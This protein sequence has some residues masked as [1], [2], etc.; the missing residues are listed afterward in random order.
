[1]STTQASTQET[2]EQ[3]EH[4][5]A[6]TTHHVSVTIITESDDETNAEFSREPYRITECIQC[7]AESRQR[8]N[9]R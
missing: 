4:C 1:M 6:K 3:C 7:G 9:D 2:V 5:E 8:M